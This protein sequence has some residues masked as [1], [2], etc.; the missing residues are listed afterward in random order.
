[1][2]GRGVYNNRGSLD[3]FSFLGDSTQQNSEDSD[4]F[5]N[6]KNMDLGNNSV[7]DTPKATFGAPV[8]TLATGLYFDSFVKES[9]QAYRKSLK[10]AQRTLPHD[11]KQLHHNHKNSLSLALATFK[12]LFDK[13]PD[14]A[15]LSEAA[16][17][18]GK[19]KLLKELLTCGDFDTHIDMNETASIDSCEQGMEAFKSVM[20]EEWPTSKVAA[21]P[22]SHMDGATL[23]LKSH[24]FLVAWER[25][26]NAFV[27]DAIGPAVPLFWPQ[28][29]K[30]LRQLIDTQILAEVNLLVLELKD[31]IN[32]AAQAQQ[33]ISLLKNEQVHYSKV[34]REGMVKGL[35][36]QEDAAVS[37]KMQKPT[38]KN[39]RMRQKNGEMKSK[40]L[41]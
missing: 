15:N 19:L 12:S 21:S 30:R 17:Q 20:N 6:P 18:A 24:K 14:V 29:T 10:Q 7:Y 11:E 22:S 32:E 25:A 2:L 38:T 27:K 23:V 4:F 36:K 8:Q 40:M 28:V 16:V 9:M 13:T 1:M 5:D 37:L 3:L 33:E 41:E 35:Q 39:G 34:L 31:A 26:E